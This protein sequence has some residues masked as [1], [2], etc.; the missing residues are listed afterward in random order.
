MKFI[1][2]LDSATAADLEWIDGQIAEGENKLDA[3]RMVR[4][5]LSIKLNGKKP[6]KPPTPRTPGMRASP[7][8]GLT[9]RQKAIKYLL[10][11][12]LSSAKAI[13]D[14]IGIEPK[15]I[16]TPLN[17]EFFTKVDD[18]RWRLTEAGRAAAKE[19]P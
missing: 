17:H 6:R 4:R 16:Y 18:G 3:L 14:A 7:G 9:V 1:E 13:A 12:G 11:A 5:V 10:A 15:E 2:A 19:I 8:G